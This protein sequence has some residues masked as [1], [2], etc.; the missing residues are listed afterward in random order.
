MGV[1]RPVGQVKEVVFPEHML[2]IGAESLLRSVPGGKK[3]VSI[4]VPEISNSF[5]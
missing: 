2:N 4:G 3:Q 1:G 5:E